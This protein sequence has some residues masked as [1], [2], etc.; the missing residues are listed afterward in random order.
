MNSAKNQA[1]PLPND[2]LAFAFNRKSTM[3]ELAGQDHDRDAARGVG[4][5]RPSR[6]VVLRIAAGAIPGSVSSGRRR[7]TA[8]AAP[9]AA[10]GPIGASGAATR[11]ATSARSP[12]AVPAAGGRRRCARPRDRSVPRSATR[13]LKQQRGARRGAS[14]SPPRSASGTVRTPIRRCAP[15][16]SVRARLRRRRRRVRSEKRATTRAS[17]VTTAV[18][19]VIIGRAATGHTLRKVASR[20]AFAA[21]W[22]EPGASTHR[23]PGQVAIHACRDSTSIPRGLLDNPPRRA[24]HAARKRTG[25]VRTHGAG[26]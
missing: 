15:R 14:E 16:R 23:H 21:I 26:Q 24:R 7:R 25:C 19:T 5:S 10:G 11:S 4:G 3:A 20:N 8:D 9:P 18:A 6:A 17:G 2:A 22:C 1:R 13:T 12:P